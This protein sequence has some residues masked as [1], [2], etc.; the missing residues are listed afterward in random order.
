VPI[1]AVA[2]SAMAWKQA[3][4]FT[5]VQTAPGKPEFPR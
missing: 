3:A 2:F 1:A 4:Q 5:A